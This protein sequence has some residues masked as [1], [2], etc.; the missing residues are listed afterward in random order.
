MASNSNN[1]IE[2]STS[3]GSGFEHGIGALAKLPLLKGN[4]V[5]WKFKMEHALRV[6]RL[7]GI[8]NGEE[9][10]PDSSP[11]KEEWERRDE[12]ARQCIVMTVDEENTS[13]LFT[14]ENA[15]EMWECLKEVFQEK[16]I[17]NILT[18]KNEFFTYK[19]DPKHNMHQ[20]V[21]KIKEMVYN[22]EAIG[23]KVD[24]NDTILVLLNSIPNEYK[25]VRTSL[26]VI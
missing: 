5:N 11:A 19:K 15:K 8:V 18:L 6:R 1:T 12:Q 16:S 17:S 13:S 4:Y 26:K 7:W 25:M 9:R 24:K 21:M 20:H 3:E 2:F 23:V 22:L 14:A 10:R